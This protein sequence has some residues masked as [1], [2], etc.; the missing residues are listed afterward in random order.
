MRKGRILSVSHSKKVPSLHQTGAAEYLTTALQCSRCQTFPLSSAV[1][2][3]AVISPRV[4]GAAVPAVA[5]AV[6]S[7]VNEFV[8]LDT[9]MLQLLAMRN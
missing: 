3:N 4:C 6:Q 5:A 7:R 8:E 9:L 2:N 1:A